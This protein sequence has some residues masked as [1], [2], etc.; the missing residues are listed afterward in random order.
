MSRGSPFEATLMEADWVCDDCHRRKE[1]VPWLSLRDSV[2]ISV[3]SAVAA[4]AVDSIVSCAN[5]D[6]AA[7]V[8]SVPGRIGR[9]KVAA[10]TRTGEER[11]RR[12]LRPV[13]RSRIGIGRDSRSRHRKVS[14]EYQGYMEEGEEIIDPPI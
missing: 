7:V 2:F 10:Y 9:S 5:P 4:E 8:T 13:W 3:G 11:R 1:H 14:K 6:G 12:V